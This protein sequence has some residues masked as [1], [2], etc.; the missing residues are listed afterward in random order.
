MTPYGFGRFASVM[1][2]GYMNVT[3]N[4][5]GQKTCDYGVKKND[6]MSG[7]DKRQTL[8]DGHCGEFPWR[9]ANHAPPALSR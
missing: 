6:P 1:Y 2:D 8:T 3:A 9:G 4:L 7:P 5:N